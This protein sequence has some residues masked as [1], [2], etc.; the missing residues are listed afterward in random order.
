MLKTYHFRVIA[1]KSQSNQKASYEFLVVISSNFISVVDRFQ[2]IATDVTKISWESPTE[3]YRK[4]WYMKTR[5]VQLP[6]MVKN[7]VTTL[8]TM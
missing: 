2:D 6:L 1:K 8:Q 3:Y 5:I 7:R 4:V